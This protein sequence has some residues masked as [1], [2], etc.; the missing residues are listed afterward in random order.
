[1]EWSIFHEYRHLADSGKV[2][3]LQCPDCTGHLITR[4]GTE[5]EPVL[6]CPSCDT[7]IQPGLDLYDQIRAVVKEHNA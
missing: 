3:H 7:R 6:W 2:K 5:D 4:L 1:M